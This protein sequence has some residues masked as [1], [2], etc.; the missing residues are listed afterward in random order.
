MLE[1]YQDT[2]LTLP[3][4]DGSTERREVEALVRQRA[5]LC[6]AIAL[7]P[8]PLLDLA[9]VLPL[10]LEMVVKIG[11]IY[12]FELSTARAKEIVLEFSGAVALTYVTRT[13][14]RSL[15]K[16]VPVLGPVLNA[17]M[18][19]TGTYSLGMLSE[20]YFRA[21]RSDLPALERK[22][23]AV[24]AQEFA[25]QAKNVLKSVRLEDWQRVARTLLKRKP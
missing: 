17:P 9:I 12:G 23:I 6:A 1:P 19:F 5:T 11:K 7:E 22:E 25:A 16:F 24:M 4:S 18:V 10:H 13:A 8:V 21:R 3:V 14:A 2:T 15:L 20:R